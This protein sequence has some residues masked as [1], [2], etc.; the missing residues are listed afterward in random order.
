[1]SQTLSQLVRSSD[2]PTPG[3]ALYIDV[4]A[5][6][7][8]PFCYLG[9]R[10]LEQ[11]LEAVQG[12]VEISW[13]PYQL[14]PDM[15][16]AGKPLADYLGERFG[17]RAAVQ[18]VLDQLAAEGR[19][20]GI[21]FDFDAITTIPNTLAAHQVM[22]LADERGVDQSA[23]A[24]DFMSAFFEDGKDI[25]ELDVIAE[26]AEP[27]GLTRQDVERAIADEAI[28]ETV[29]S[30]EAQVR[31]SGMSGAPGFLLNRRLLVVGAQDADALINAFDRAMFGEGN[32]EVVSPALH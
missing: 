13:Y 27:H 22:H 6:L 23:L 15:P 18:P 8:C 24:E 28:R 7:V 12:P 21:E 2:R 17:S 4:I 31:A 11:A 19:E 9:K 32:D 20:Y 3:G 10:R 1:M 16:S 29:V 14:N 26:I 5:D 25:G 30:R